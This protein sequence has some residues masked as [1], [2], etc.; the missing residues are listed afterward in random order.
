[1]YSGLLGAIRKAGDVPLTELKPYLWQDE[2]QDP[3]LLTRR[4][5]IYLYDDKTLGVY[6]FFFADAPTMQNIGVISDVWW[7]D[8]QLGMCKAK[9]QN[10]PQLLHCGKKFKIRPNIKGRWIVEMEERIGHKI[11]PYNPEVV[12]ERNGVQPECLRRPC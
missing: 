11:L 1:M 9:I 12:M 7:T 6:L 2:L 8:D 10:L 5:E 3:F 4:M